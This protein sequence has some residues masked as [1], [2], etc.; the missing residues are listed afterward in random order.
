[1]FRSSKKKNDNN[2]VQNNVDIAQDWLKDNYIV[3]PNWTKPS[4]LTKYQ[5]LIVLRQPEGEKRVVVDFSLTQSE[6]ERLHNESIEG[7]IVDL[8]DENIFRM[9]PTSINTKEIE[10]A[11]FLSKKEIEA[12]YNDLSS[13]SQEFELIQNDVV[14]DQEKI[15]TILRMED[16]DIRIIDDTYYRENFEHPIFKASE[17]NDSEFGFI[18]TDERRELR[19]SWSNIDKYI[20][21]REE[22]DDRLK[23]KYQDFQDNPKEYIPK[24]QPMF[25]N[26][27]DVK[28]YDNEQEQENIG[29]SEEDNLIEITINNSNNEIFNELKYEERHEYSDNEGNYQNSTHENDDPE[30]IV[31]NLDKTQSLS[32][33]VEDISF[34]NDSDDVVDQPKELSFFKNTA[35]VSIRTNYSVNRN[36]KYI[37]FYKSDREFKYQKVKLNRKKKMYMIKKT[38]ISKY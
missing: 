5:K 26:I 27:L 37:K 2:Y 33:Y 23:N 30:I 9:I 7:N 10:D 18:E 3:V 14:L 4:Q 34:E 20:E 31:D 38:L 19:E 12:I 22:I 16:K 15:P 8:N 6:K 24:V 25:R 35:D 29:N 32:N 11:N 17:N 36:R 1:M 13:T 21:I 28:V